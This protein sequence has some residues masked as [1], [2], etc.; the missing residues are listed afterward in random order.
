MQLFSAREQVSAMVDP[1]PKSGAG[2]ADSVILTA[3][4]LLLLGRGS[5]TRQ[6]QG[7]QA[8]S[9]QESQRQTGPL[10]ATGAGPERVGAQPGEHTALRAPGT[11]NGL[12]GTAAQRLTARVFSQHMGTDGSNS[13]PRKPNISLVTLLICSQGSS[14]K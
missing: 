10:S 9:L 5:S 12:L 11:L 8:G 7:R 1:T 13:H 6:G 2:E 3:G 14:C 4:S